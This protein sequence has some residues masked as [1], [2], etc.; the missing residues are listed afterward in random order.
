L[1]SATDAKKIFAE[2]KMKKLNP[3]VLREEVAIFVAKAEYA[4]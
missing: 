2:E 4:S 1:E 3:I